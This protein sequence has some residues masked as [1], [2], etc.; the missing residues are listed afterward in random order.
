MKT[1]KLDDMVRGWFVGNFEPTVFATDQAE[2]GV[3]SY[4]AG[5]REAAHYHKIATEITVIVTGE[6][7]MNGVRYRAGDIICI[8]PGEATDFYAISDA[9]TAVIKVPCVKGDKY[10]VEVDHA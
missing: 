5:E 4:H 1:A 8:E 2:A 7:E 10:L 6:V 9:Q 3:K